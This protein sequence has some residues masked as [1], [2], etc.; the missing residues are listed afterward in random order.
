MQK[1]VVIT[2]NPMS[3]PPEH[4]LQIDDAI[5][6][7]ENHIKTKGVPF[8]ATLSFIVH[9]QEMTLDEYEKLTGAEGDFGW[10]DEKKQTMFFPRPGG[11]YRYFTPSNP[12]PTDKFGYV[13]GVDPYRKEEKKEP[14]NI[15]LQ[16]YI[17]ELTPKQLEILHKLTT[18]KYDPKPE[19]LITS[20]EYELLPNF[21]KGYAHYLQSSWEQSNIPKDEI[22]SEAFRKGAHWATIEIQDMED[23]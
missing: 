23:L 10:D 6:F 4:F 2:V 3:E 22:D 16:E 14:M 18:W 19:G 13:A 21:L 7:M 11:K 8:R 20:D 15:N 5:A 9:V 12:P 17:S 1:Q